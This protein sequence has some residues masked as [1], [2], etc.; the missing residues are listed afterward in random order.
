M[1]T[2]HHLEYSQSFRILWL[3]EELGAQYELKTYR[4]DPETNL[5]PDDYKALSPLGTA[6]VVTDGDL[7]LAESNAIIDHVLDAYPDSPLRPGPGHPDRP[8]HL[9]WFHA[10]QGSLMSIQGVAMVLTLLES[11]TPWPIGALLKAIF[12]QVRKLF[13]NPRLDALFA[14]M[15]RDLAEKP[16]FGG[17][18]LTAA[19]I[20]LVYPMFAA[21]EKGAFEHGFPNTAR[22]FD[23]VEAMESFRAARAKDDRDSIV[24]RF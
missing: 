8:R 16:F 15:E 12:G 9:F 20:T 11:R 18:N 21:R 23:R 17:D 22:W 14:L 13:V 10:A 4:R 7:V 1:L 19:D 2:L 6:P 24:F 3:L 5:V